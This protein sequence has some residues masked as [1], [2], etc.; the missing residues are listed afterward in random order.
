MIRSITILFIY[1]LFGSLASLSF[2]QDSDK[3]VFISNMEETYTYDLN[4]NGEVQI[5]AEY[6]INYKCIKP[7]TASFVEYYD[8]YSEIKNVKIRGMKGISPKYGMYKRENIFFS[9]AKAC[10]FDIPFIQ[11]DTEATVTYNKHYKDIRRFL[12]LP[13]AELYHT[14]S[15]TIKFVIPDWLDIDIVSENL[16]ENILISSTKDKVKKTTITII[17]IIN[18]AEYFVEDNSPHYMHSQP[19]IMMVPREFLGK[20][21]STTYFKTVDDLYRWSKEPL[22]L[23]DNNLSLIKGK[24]SE[25]TKNCI[26][27]DEKIRELCRWV[28][29]NIRYIAFMDGI[30]AFKPDNAQDVIAK[31]YGDCKGMSNLL[32]SLLIAEGFDARLVWVA[33]TDAERNLKT[34]NPMPFANHMICALYKN[35][36]LYYFDPTVKSLIFG[37]IPEQIQGQMALIE[38]GEKYVINQIPQYNADYNRDSLFVKYSV[39]DNRLIGKATRTFKG[40]SKHS[41]SYWMNTMSEME[42]KY[43]IEV[44]LKNGGIGDSIFDIQANGL[45]SFMPEINLIYGVNRQSNIDV[46][47]NKLYLNLDETK[48]YQDAKIDIKKRKTALKYPCRDYTVRVSELIIPDGY[49]L[50]QLPP[51]IS[52]NQNKYSFSVFYSRNGNKITYNKKIFIIDPIFEKADFEQWNSDIDTLR[53]AYG[54]LVVLEK[55]Q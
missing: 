22:L 18:Q 1:I 11:K 30:S 51:N 33:T 7:T 41:I 5:N 10:Y 50:S 31:R 36:S 25:L 24:A 3:K 40:E 39:A 52:I 35:D 15:R 46:F 9:D 20:N 32:K 23:I 2:A 16:S 27:D 44:F 38:N 34:E 17:N 14:N 6:V 43:K 28:Q 4:K 48:D 26:S 13:L 53:K 55:K 37:E 54:E 12:V 47:G 42:K 45:G 29:K 49:D 19:Y 8:D 21:G